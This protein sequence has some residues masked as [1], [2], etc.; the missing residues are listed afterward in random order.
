MEAVD[1][2]IKGA[3]MTRN[4]HTVLLFV[5]LALL[6]LAFMASSALSVGEAVK[7]V[8]VKGNPQIMKAQK[9]QWESCAIEMAVG[10]GDRIKTSG[11]EAVD[12]AFTLKSTV[13]M[14]IEEN[15]D[16]FIKN[17]ASPYSTELLNGAVMASIGGLP[18]GSKFEVRTPT[19]VSGARGTA[20]RSST[21]GNRSV[22]DSFE[23]SIYIIGIDAAGKEMEGELTVESGFRAVVDRFE[24]PSRIE[25]L[26]G[27][28]MERWSEWKAEMREGG[29]G[30]AISDRLDKIDSIVTKAEQ[31]EQRRASGVNEF[32]D[33]NR[34]TDRLTETDRGS[35]QEHYQYS[36]T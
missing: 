7:I 23:K 8:M 21:D 11:G 15:S 18:R 1:K 4:R 27:A 12:I 34:I 20:W 28:D 32:E 9:A 19:A 2:K 6:A 16:V 35:T 25:K 24:R 33:V 36:G 10:T 22:F 26:S 30:G 14:R 13:A 29:A 3:R 17:N 31:A 5:S